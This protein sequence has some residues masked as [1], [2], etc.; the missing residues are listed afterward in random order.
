MVAPANFPRST[1]LGRYEEYHPYGSTAWWAGNAEIEVSRKRYRYTGMERDEETGLQCHGVRYYAPWIGRWTSADPIGLGDGGNRF[2][3]C[4]GHA[5]HSRDASGLAD[6]APLVPGETVELTAQPL[7][8]EQRR[9]L[10]A[11]KVMDQIDKTDLATKRSGQFSEY[12]VVIAENSET[13]EFRVSAVNHGL[14]ETEVKAH[15]SIGGGYSSKA[16]FGP[17]VRSLNE[18]EGGSRWYYSGDGHSHP[19]PGPPDLSD[20]EAA[21]N[22]FNH[23]TVYGIGVL[24]TPA[25]PHAESRDNAYISV[26]DP[27]EVHYTPKQAALKS[28]LESASPDNPDDDRALRSP[29]ESAWALSVVAGD[30]GATLFSV[31]NGKIARVDPVT[32][33]WA[34]RWEQHYDASQERKRARQAR[35][36]QE[37]GR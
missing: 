5:T 9:E 27:G 15:S 28:K 18:K 32:P 36:G 17:F 16:Y 23:G 10:V 12:G 7:T 3:Y 14:N 11:R 8:D 33:A 29:G 20:V 31:S 13:G 22:P 6:D 21:I 24:L 2:G 34:L 25:T 1:A 30:R 19:D 35:K 4:G 26:R 37:G